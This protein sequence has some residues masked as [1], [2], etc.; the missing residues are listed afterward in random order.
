M[1]LQFRQFR[2]E[3]C[4]QRLRKSDISKNV[5]HYIHPT[6]FAELEA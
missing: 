2:Q 5:D 4:P 3:N 6:H 1:G